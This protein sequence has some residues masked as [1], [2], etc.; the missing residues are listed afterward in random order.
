M[1]PAYGGKRLAAQCRRTTKRED[2]VVATGE[3]KQGLRDLHHECFACG[4]GNATGLNLHFEVGPDGIARASWEPLSGFLSYSDRV[5][6]GVIATL[7]D[8]AFVHALFAKGVVGVTAELTVRYLQKVDCAARVEGSGWIEADGHGLY[9]C[10]GEVRQSGALAAR[11]SAK[12]AKL[13]G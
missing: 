1:G 3:R 11:A 8:S 10:R 2:S 4:A 12:F 6:G 9:Y 7:L 5:H 13:P